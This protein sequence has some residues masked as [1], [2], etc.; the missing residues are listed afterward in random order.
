ML[1]NL[2]KWALGQS[3]RLAAAAALVVT[4]AASQ[5]AWALRWACVS[6]RVGPC[7]ATYYCELWTDDGGYAGSISGWHCNY[8]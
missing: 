6:Q 4:L 8:C 1:D 7:C 2:E 5:P 3:K